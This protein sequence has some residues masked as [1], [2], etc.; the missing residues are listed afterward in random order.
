MSEY[1][2]GYTNMLLVVWVDVNISAQS[3]GAE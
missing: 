1:Y 3:R 2:M